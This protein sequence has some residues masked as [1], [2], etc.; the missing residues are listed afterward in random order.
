VL[1]EIDLTEHAQGSPEYGFGAAESSPVVDASRFARNV[2]R[3]PG[4]VSGIIPDRSGQFGQQVHVA[5]VRRGDA[6][7]SRRPIV[8]R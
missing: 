7:G 6:F 4:Y 2:T 3:L 8:T 1:G 5:M